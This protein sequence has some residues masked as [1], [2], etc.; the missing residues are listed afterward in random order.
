[1]A[2]ITKSEILNVLKKVKVPNV[3]NDNL[4]LNSIKNFSLKEDAL[5]FYLSVQTTDDKIEKE[6]Y[7]KLADAIKAEYP[8]IK[9][10]H[11]DVGAIKPQVSTHNDPKKNQCFPV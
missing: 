7:D 8:S 9:E 4:T 6:V 5:K 3:K 1:M 2:D 11:M 10:I